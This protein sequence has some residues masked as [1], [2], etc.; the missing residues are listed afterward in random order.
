MRISSWFSCPV[1]DVPLGLIAASSDLEQGIEPLVGPLG[2]ALKSVWV[3]WSCWQFLRSAGGKWERHAVHLLRRLHLL[4]AG[5]LVW[6]GHPQGHRVHKEE[7]GA[8]ALAH[9]L[10]H[11]RTRFRTHTNSL[12]HT[13]ILTHA[14]SHTQIPTHT[15]SQT[16]LH[17]LA[18]THMPRVLQLS[19]YQ[20]LFGRMWQLRYDPR[21]FGFI[22]SSY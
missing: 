12:S 5:R 22:L 4:H 9:T 20:T 19:H 10:T 16:L 7:Y 1:A 14:Y 8:Y 18:H 3:C 17:T 13:H 2:T 21:T 15:H 6:D 11:T